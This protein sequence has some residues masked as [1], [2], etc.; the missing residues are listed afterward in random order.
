M[1]VHVDVVSDAVEVRFTG[2][3]IGLALKR[4]LRIL[5]TEIVDVR[6]EDAKVARRLWGW[7]IAGGYWPGWFATGHFTVAKTVRRHKGECALLYSFGRS[8]VL[9]IETTRL[10]PRFVALQ[11]EDPE[12]LQ[13]RIRG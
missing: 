11:V 13:S 4:R 5:L 3:A 7:R 8:R 9:V 6:V 2:W 12:R 10:R 1:G